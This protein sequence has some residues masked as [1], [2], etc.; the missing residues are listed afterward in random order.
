MRTH[1]S[2]RLADDKECL[3]APLLMAEK[4][5]AKI[6]GIFSCDFDQPN[7][8]A[9]HEMEPFDVA[10]IFNTLDCAVEDEDALLAALERVNK[11][12]KVGAWLV[13]A[14]PLGRSFYRVAPADS[15]SFHSF[16]LSED[17]LRRGLQHAGFDEVKYESK[18]FSDHFQCPQLG[19]LFDGSGMFVLRAKKVAEVELDLSLADEEEAE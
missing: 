11:V 6:G 12:L 16:P 5:R 14:G 3:E 17:N 18:A 10:T 19:E 13:I 9:P 8:L 7:I 15:T 4:V 1:P 2:A